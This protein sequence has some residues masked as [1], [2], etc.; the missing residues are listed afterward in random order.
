MKE[1]V[2]LRQ[3]EQ[4]RLVTLNAVG[5]GQLTV[6]EAADVLGLSERQVRR[7]Y[8][9]YEEK[10][11]AALAHGNRGRTPPNVLDARIRQQVIALAGGKY[12]GCNQVHLTEL[13]AERDE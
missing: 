7:L 10:G 11:A 9:A 6:G 13:L 3:K 2:T 1:Q 5:R 12:A 8:A 4:Q